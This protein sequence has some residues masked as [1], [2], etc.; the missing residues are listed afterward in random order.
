MT[1]DHD[2]IDQL[3]EELDHD[4]DYPE[5]PERE[6]DDCRDP[7]IPPCPRGDCD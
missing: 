2:P 3:L 5:G 1:P 4:T 6:L 7:W